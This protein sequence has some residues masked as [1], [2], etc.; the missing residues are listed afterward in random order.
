[1]KE[2]IT[3]FELVE[4]FI[5]L[6][7]EDLSK[8]SFEDML[9]RWEDSIGRVPYLY[10]PIKTR[11]DNHFFRAVKSEWH[12]VIPLEWIGYPPE[13]C[14]YRNRCNWEKHPVLYTSMHPTTTLY[15]CNARE[16]DSFYIS[17]WKIN[18]SSK[19]KILPWLYNY[20]GSISWINTSKEISFDKLKEY[21]N[22]KNL[23]FNLE[24][25]LFILITDSFLDSGHF[26]S[27][28]IS[29]YILFDNNKDGI[30]TILY[31][32]IQYKK[33][34]INVAFHH[35]LVDEQILVPDK[36]AFVKVVEVRDGKISY[37]VT[38]KIGRTENGKIYFSDTT[39]EEIQKE[40]KGLI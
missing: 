3:V 35:K 5:R 32:S 21:C 8:V 31:P 9:K 38:H 13:K 11:V 19:I 20:N 6:K 27:S 23:D 18:D 15:E 14:C 25:L 10:F 24:R 12:S 4:R 28:F 2:S 40:F 29:H 34:Q 30:N 37:G 36:V 22:E 16:G 39:E 7:N 17:S 1:M 33:D 26:I